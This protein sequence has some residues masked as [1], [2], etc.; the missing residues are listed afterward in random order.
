VVG[1]RRAEATEHEGA[2]TQDTGYMTP[3][4]SVSSP[5]PSTPLGM[6][7]VETAESESES[8][9]SEREM[10]SKKPKLEVVG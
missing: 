4:N 1:L 3:S 7:R 6:A 10:P 5:P 9:E 2:E 8:S